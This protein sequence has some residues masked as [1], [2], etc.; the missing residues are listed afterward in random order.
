MTYIDEQ[1]LTLAKILCG[2]GVFLG[3]LAILTLFVDSKRLANREKIKEAYIQCVV[4]ANSDISEIA[5]CTIK[6]QEEFQ[7]TGK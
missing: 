4:E 2:I 5:V 7:K 1:L 6:F 3:G